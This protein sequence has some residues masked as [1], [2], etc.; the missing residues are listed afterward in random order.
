MSVL[1]ALAAGAAIGVRHSFEPDHVAAVATLVDDESDDHAGLVGTSWGIGHS[2]P[3]ALVALA[4]LLA[5]RRLPDGVTTLFE[6]LAGAIL[7]YLG[8]RMLYRLVDVTEHTHDG[9][10][11]AH[12]GL[13]S[14]SLGATHSHR[15][16]ESFL[17]GIVHGLAGSGA[18]VV[19]L[20][21]TAPTLGTGL[22]L[23]AAFCVASIATMGALT[24]LWGRVL[25][26]AARK[27]LQVGAAL[28]SLAVGAALLLGEFADGGRGHGHAHGTGHEHAVAAVELSTEYAPLVAELGL[29]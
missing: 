6:V 14:L 19:V 21:T 2:I 25:D 28:A 27:Y 17:V 22:V 24:L 3:I 29:C 5:G 16:D 1:A 20:V 11:H 12:V 7:V 13:G 4:F 9:H 23:L 10:T 8:A 26:T 15:A 18:F